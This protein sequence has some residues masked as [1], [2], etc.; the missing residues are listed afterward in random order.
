MKKLII[1]SFCL[2]IGVLAVAQP[3]IKGTFAIKNVHTG[4]VLR[5][6]DA[7][8]KDGTPIVAYSP[9]NWKC[10]TWDFKHIEGNTYQLK[11]LFSGKTLQSA[12]P[13]VKEGAALQEQPLSDNALQRYEFIPAD[14]NSYL[15]KLKGKELYLTPADKDGTV[16][17]KIIFAKKDGSKL[18]YWTIQ[19]QHPTM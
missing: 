9:V 15:I 6:K 2:I 1:V 18:Q 17:S 10:V 16:N 3:V 13:E 7:N 4:M 12:D 14:K 5:I 8:A 19:E 11:N